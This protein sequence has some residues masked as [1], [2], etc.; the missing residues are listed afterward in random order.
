MK[1][2]IKAIWYSVYARYP[3]GHRTE[4]MK[5]ENVKTA[6]VYARKCAAHDDGKMAFEV[7]K[8]EVCVV[9]AFTKETK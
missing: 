1:K 6:T 9:P 3:D 4:L 7:C 2:N 8:V 5:F